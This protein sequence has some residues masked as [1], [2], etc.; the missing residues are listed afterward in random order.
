[1]APIILSLQ[2]KETAPPP[3]MSDTFERIKRL[4]AGGTVR[5]S[6]HGYDELTADGIFARDVLSSIAQGMV[7]EDYPEYPK[8]PC[9]LVLQHDSVGNPLHIVWG[10][11]KGR[12][13][14][15]VLVTAYRPDPAVWQDGYTR[16]RT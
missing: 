2:T 13:E 14:P 3:A 12:T 15:A 9:T 4:A 6:D 10:I 8:G 16:R 5:I 1:M 11:P 7:V